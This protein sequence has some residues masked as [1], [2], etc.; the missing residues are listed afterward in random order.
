MMQTIPLMEIAMKQA[1]TLRDSEAI[2][3]FCLSK[4]SKLPT[5]VVGHNVKQKLG[6]EDCPAILIPRM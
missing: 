1:E 4:Y 3:D 2:R 6:K 5:I